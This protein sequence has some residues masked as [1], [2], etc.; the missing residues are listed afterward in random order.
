M[1]RAGN[2][3]EEAGR[4]NKQGE[5]Y[6]SEEGGEWEEGGAGGSRERSICK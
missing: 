5:A 6:A 4:R 3:R 1:T 2:E